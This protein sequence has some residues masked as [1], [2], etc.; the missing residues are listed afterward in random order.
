MFLLELL[1]IPHTAVK[2]CWFFTSTDRKRRKRWNRGGCCSSDRG[3]RF[4]RQNSLQI[5]TSGLQD[6]VL[7][8]GSQFGIAPFAFTYLRCSEYENQLTSGK[9]PKGWWMCCWCCCSCD[10]AGRGNLTTTWRRRFTRQWLNWIRCRPRWEQPTASQ[11]LKQT[12]IK[13][14]GAAPDLPDWHL[15]FSLPLPLSFSLAFTLT[16]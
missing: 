5:S 9:Q 13:V 11:P 7:I 8:L 6:V 1:L 14:G 4:V 2:A 12:L 15:P 10:S 16:P 3:V